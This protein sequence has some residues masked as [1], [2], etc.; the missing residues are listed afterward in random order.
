MANLVEWIEEY[1]SE[2]EIEGVVIG[3]MGWGTYHSEHVPNYA[4]QPKGK[5]ISWDEA[6]KWL[7]YEFDPGFGAPQCNAV[8][9]W[10][11]RDIF[12]VGQYDGSTFPIVLPRNPEDIM[13]DM[14]GG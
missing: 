3:E 12:L 6:K 4:D 11:K 13:P 2:D 9:V 8:Y 7:N 1:F 5:V 14:P 10:G